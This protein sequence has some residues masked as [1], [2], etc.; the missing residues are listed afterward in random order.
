MKLSKK[1]KLLYA[2]ALFYFPIFWV[3]LCVFTA[4]PS[5]IS[6]RLFGSSTLTLPPCGRAHQV[7]RRGPYLVPGT[8]LL[9]AFEK[10]FYIAKLNGGVSAW[11]IASGTRCNAWQRRLIGRRVQDALSFFACRHSPFF[12]PIFFSPHHF[13]AADLHVD[14]VVRKKGTEWEEIKKRLYGLCIKQT[15]SSVG[16]HLPPY[17]PSFCS[18]TLYSS[19]SPFMALVLFCCLSFPFLFSYNCRSI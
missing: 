15:L 14:E 5:S 4:F 6:W 3:L 11:L 16:D 8:H 13:L 19:G 12:S 17:F 9:Q 18:P 7:Y 1:N 10:T 2:I